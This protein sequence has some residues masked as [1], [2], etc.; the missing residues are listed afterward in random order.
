MQEQIKSISI[1]KLKAGVPFEDKADLLA[2]EEPL[3]IRIGYGQA[4]ERIQKSISVTMRT[5]AHDHELALGF[6]FSEGIIQSFDDIE[7]IRH[8]EDVGKEETGNIVRVELRPTVQI[9]TAKLQR[10]FYTTSSCGVCG[11]SSLEAISN[12]CKPIQSK[13]QV[14]HEV[15]LAA[16]PKLRSSQTV[17]AHTGGIHA[18]G[19]FDAKG[20]LIMLREDVGRHNAFDKVIG[21]CL[22]KGMVPLSDYLVLVSGR[23]SFELAQKAVMAGLPIMAAVGAPSSLAVQLAQRFRLTLMGFLKQSTLNIYNNANRVV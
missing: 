1:Q 13:L 4:R 9:N 15:V 17:F 19:L 2:V 21:A 20:Q 3:E 7:G 8:C 14:S 5:P 10:H 18:T 16:P 6:L 11:K 12:Q 22:A 23:A